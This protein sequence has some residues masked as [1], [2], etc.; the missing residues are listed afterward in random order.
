VI[1]VIFDEPMAEVSRVRDPAPGQF[2]LAFSVV[3]FFRREARWAGDQEPETGR[4]LTLSLRV[5]IN[6]EP[7]VSLAQPRA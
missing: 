4:A 3:G 5:R 6:C 2:S 7:R 1:F